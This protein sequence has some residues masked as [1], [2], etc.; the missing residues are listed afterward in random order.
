MDRILKK[1][2]RKNTESFYIPLYI[3]YYVEHKSQL[4]GKSTGD[5]IKESILLNSDFKEV[6]NDFFESSKL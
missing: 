3:K 6:I 5:I 1:F 4:T 2:K